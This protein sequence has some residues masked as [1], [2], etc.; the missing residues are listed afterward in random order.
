MYNDDL[1]TSDRM[2]YTLSRPNHWDPV[3]FG[4]L[5]L[6]LGNARRHS[7]PFT[8]AAVGFA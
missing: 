2:A 5:C 7:N 8:S 1:D 3:G 4:G 6:L